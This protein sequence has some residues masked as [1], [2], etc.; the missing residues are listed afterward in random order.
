MHRLEEEIKQVITARCVCLPLLPHRK[1]I[2]PERERLSLVFST[3]FQNVAWG[4][5]L[6]TC[7]SKL[8]SLIKWLFLLNSFAPC[9]AFLEALCLRWA[10]CPGHLWGKWPCY[11]SIWQIKQQILSQER[12]KEGLK[13]MFDV[14]TVTFIESCNMPDTILNILLLLIFVL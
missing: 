7:L 12:D 6:S 2:S 3:R 14:Q 9:Q 4:L 10:Y 13:S 11:P 1:N 8:L 5:A